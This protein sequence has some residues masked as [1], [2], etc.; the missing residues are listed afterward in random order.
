MAQ[1]SQELSPMMKQYLEIKHRHEDSILF[2]RL[3]DFYEMF[4]EDAKVASEELDLVL[5]GRDCG[6]EERAPMCGVP[7]H[8][9]ESYI[10]RLVERGYKVAIC[11]QTE[12]PAEAKGIVKRDVIR[13]ITPGTVIENT[14][15]DEGKNNYLAAGALLGSTVGLCFVDASTGDVHLT[16]LSGD[17]LEN[18][19]VSELTRFSP[20]EILL[21][22]V[23]D[24]MLT[25]QNFLKTRFEGTVTKRGLSGFES[26]FAKD[27]LRAYFKTNDLSF[28]PA[29]PDSA[30][31]CALG[32]TVD[33]LKEMGITGNIVPSSISYYV[34]DEFM[35]LD[36]TAMRNLELTETMRQKSK[37]G[38]L[39]WVIDKTKTA[40]G[41]RLIRGWMEKPLMSITEINNRLNAVE[42]LCDDV[43]LSGELREYLTGVRDVERLMAR[44][45]YGTALPKDLLDLASTIR[46]FGL[47]K[48]ALQNAKSGM[49]KGICLQID[50]LSEVCELVENAISPEAPNSV[51]EGKIFKK[52]YDPKIDEVRDD[53]EGGTG[54]IASIEAEEKERTGIKTLKV[55]YNK[56]FG[57][58][59][60]VSN[61]FLDK[62]PETYIR[63]QTLTNGE[64][65]IT[66]E[67]K[68]LEVRILSA[69][70]RDG[71]MEFE[72]YEKIRLYIAEQ[73]ERLQITATAVA[74][75]D[76]LASLSSV[77]VKN[78][79]CRPRLNTDGVI[80]I[81]DGRHPV[82]ELLGDTPFVTNDTLL[83]LA[84]NRCAII[85]GPNMAG[86]S[87]YM[88]QVAL[89]SILAQIGSFVP[90]TN[91][92]I[93][94]CD[95]VY[96]RVG[97]SDDLAMGQST[98]M[99]EMSEVASIVKNATKNSLLILDEIGRGTST[100]D[101]M[102]IARAV[103]EYV[104]D[105]RKLGAKTLF[106]THYHE[107]TQ[108]EKELSGV[109]NYNIAVKRKG[110]DI[111]FLRRIVPGGADDSYGVAVAKLAGV[112]DSIIK[113]ANEILRDVEAN[114]VTVI[115]SEAAS[116]PQ[117]ALDM[118]GQANELAEELK[119]LDVNTL[120]PIEAMSTLFELVKKAKENY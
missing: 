30:A 27:K 25:V 104:N 48:D 59:I 61:S 70:E 41:K 91:A 117:M 14:M 29:H 31:V 57:Y 37:K 71:A 5:T 79:Y 11:E 34:Q 58:Y 42:E 97:A 84:D 68:D 69:R 73:L 93:C 60:E 23:L 114:G 87:T 118:G 88:R 106:A 94:I 18:R 92:N 54:R 110:E 75:L 2:F 85:T 81:Q 107:L 113:R 95:A 8:S 62:V 3:G 109:K 45:V 51:R 13:V 67:L 96:T 9:C 83:D 20:S 7:Y 56:V 16:E 10:A 17:D 49:L 64:R 38:S 22:P 119:K 35:R 90:A 55:R 50:P 112:P 19:I 89:M 43:M 102:S 80:S 103:L 26:N 105:K 4:F 32:G 47:I 65:F 44:V 98:F 40:M 24:A 6:Q 28:L 72:L 66:E 1:K 63:K 120:T 21:T 101:G 115:K 74:R 78:N 76:C 53:M 39:L 108:M 77:A 52:G 86:K 12:N 82:V 111:I 99:V 36:M 116:V 46:K 33:Y 15:L 100:F